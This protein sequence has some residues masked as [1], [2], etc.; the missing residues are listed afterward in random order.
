MS[1]YVEPTA[2]SLNF[3]SLIDYTEPTGTQLDFELY[4]FDF[5]VVNTVGTVNVGDEVVVLELD[6][7]SV[8]E[9]DD[10]D[11]S[12]EVREVGNQFYQIS[13]SQTV[14]SAGSYQFTAGGLSYN[15]EHEF[16]ATALGL[17]SD[18]EEYRTFGSIQSF[19]TN[20]FT[21]WS[22]TLSGN[23]ITEVKRP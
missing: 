5:P 4:D 18:N 11:I 15:T 3:D 1:R 2:N 16:R 23:K 20:G 17:N 13:D 8:G 21:L 12:F 10:I 6:V 22:N 9:D 14:S 19:K 7:V